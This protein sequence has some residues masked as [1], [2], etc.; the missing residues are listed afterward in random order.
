[1]KDTEYKLYLEKIIYDLFDEIRTLSDDYRF[2]IDD[3]N[4]N[5]NYILKT[6]KKEYKKHYKLKE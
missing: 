2:D 6:F 3:E 4:S 5:Y 1:M